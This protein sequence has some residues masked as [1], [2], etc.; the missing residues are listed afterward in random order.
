MVHVFQFIV[1]E[2]CEIASAAAETPDYGTVC[3]VDLVDGAGVVGVDDVIP[4]RVCVDGVDVATTGIRPFM[5][6]TN[7]EHLT[8]NQ[9]VCLEDKSHLQEHDLA[10]AIQSRPF[11]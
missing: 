6:Q 10:N 2:D 3:A 1:L 8:S 11:S 4:L 9:D 5:I 7:W